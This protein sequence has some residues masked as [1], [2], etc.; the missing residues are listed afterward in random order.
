MKKNKLMIEYVPNK[1]WKNSKIESVEKIQIGIIDGAVN[2]ALFNDYIEYVN[3]TKNND[4][5]FNATHSAVICSIIKD[6]YPSSEL[7]VSQVNCDEESNKEESRES[8]M[9]ALEWLVTIQL[10]QIKVFYMI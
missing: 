5:N 4:E 10:L 8:I 6:I 7:Y 1:I 9:R 3:F 2:N